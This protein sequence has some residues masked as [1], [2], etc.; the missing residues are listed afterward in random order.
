[1][2]ESYMI[3]ITIYCHITKKINIIASIKDKNKYSTFK[4]SY[5]YTYQWC[6][7]KSRRGK[8]KKL[9]A[10]RSNSNTVRFNF[11]TYIILSINLVS[12]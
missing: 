3:L 5:M 8:N 10:L 12:L 2:Q 6:G 11:Q 7:F 1:M 9:T 4:I